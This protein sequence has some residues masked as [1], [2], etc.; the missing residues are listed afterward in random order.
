MSAEPKH[1]PFDEFIRDAPALFNDMERDGQ[2]VVIERAGKSFTLRPTRA[3]RR[4]KTG[5]ILPDDPLW[6]LVGAGSS[7][8]PNNDVAR[9]KYKYLADAYASHG[10]DQPRPASAGRDESGR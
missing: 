4:K 6:E 8:E 9:N 1:I 10:I 3:R 2:P 7:G 5:I